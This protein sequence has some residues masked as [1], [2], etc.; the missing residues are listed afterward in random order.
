MSHNGW[1]LDSINANSAIFRR[2]EQISELSLELAAGQ[3]RRR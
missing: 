3:V 2:G 1:T